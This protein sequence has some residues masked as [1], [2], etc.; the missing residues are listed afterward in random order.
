M[1]VVVVSVSVEVVEVI[2]VLVEVV[3]EL[4]LLVDLMDNERRWQYSLATAEWRPD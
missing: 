2:V 3:V 1:V 4:C